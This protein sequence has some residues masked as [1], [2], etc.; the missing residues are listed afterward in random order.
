MRRWD[1]AHDFIDKCY[2]HQRRKEKNNA[3]RG[4]VWAPG[5]PA[6]ACPRLLLPWKARAVLQNCGLTGV[7][8]EGVFSFQKEELSSKLNHRGLCV[9][10]SFFSL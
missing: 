3:G 9:P 4:T 2:K 6:A 1:Q 7:R 8:R 10:V 5:S